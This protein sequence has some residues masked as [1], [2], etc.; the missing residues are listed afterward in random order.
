MPRYKCPF[1]E[2][3]SLGELG[4]KQRKRGDSIPAEDLSG[5]QKFINYLGNISVCLAVGEMLQEKLLRCL[6]APSVLAFE[7][8]FDLVQHSI[9]M[10]HFEALYHPMTV[11]TPKNEAMKRKKFIT[12]PRSQVMRKNGKQIC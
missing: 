10:A 3:I 11:E 5:E 7:Y 2:N 6:R 1:P 4:W 8:I 12:A 9:L